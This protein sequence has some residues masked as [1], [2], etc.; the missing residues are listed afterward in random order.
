MI[1]EKAAVYV[2]EIMEIDDRL[3]LEF[4][5]TVYQAYQDGYKAGKSDPYHWVAFVWVF[6]CGVALGT[7]LWIALGDKI[8]AL[9]LG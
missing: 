5:T 2:K 4:F 7:E 6:I 1:D 9:I 3:D 8:K